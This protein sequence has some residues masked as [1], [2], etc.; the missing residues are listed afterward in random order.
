MT[1]LMVFLTILSGLVQAGVLPDLRE[2]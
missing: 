2:F 1:L